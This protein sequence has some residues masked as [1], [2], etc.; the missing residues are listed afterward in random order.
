[1]IVLHCG[2]YGSD[3]YCLNGNLSEQF[4]YVYCLVGLKQITEA[5]SAYQVRS[6]RQDLHI[7]LEHL[8][9]DVQCTFL[10]YIGT[11]NF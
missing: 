1:M 8:Q 5:G 2:S 11:S 7:R 4:C 6:L 9:L 3:I 10:N